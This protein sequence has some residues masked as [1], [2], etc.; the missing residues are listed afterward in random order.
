MFF[1]KSLTNPYVDYSNS[2]VQNVHV[3]REFVRQIVR[4]DKGKI[5][6]FINKTRVQCECLMHIHQA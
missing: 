2:D 6:D 1:N 5:S 3:V 4:F